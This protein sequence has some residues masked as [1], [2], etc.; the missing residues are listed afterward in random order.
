MNGKMTKE[1]GTKVD[2]RKDKVVVNGKQVTMPDNKGIFW[3]ALNKPKD[4]LSTLDDDKGRTTIRSLIPKASDL[5]LVTV[6]R[7]DRDNTGLLLLTN[8]VG[9]IHPLTH[10]SY[11]ISKRYELV[12]EGFV[13]DAAIKAANEGSVF[14]LTNRQFPRCTLEVL[15]VDKVNRLTLLEF[16]ANDYTSTLIEELIE[17][18]QCKLVSSR[19]TGF[20]PLR[21]KG[22]KKGEWRELSPAE[23]VK[24]KAACKKLPNS[25]IETAKIVGQERAKDRAEKQLQRELQYNPGRI[26]PET[27]RRVYRPG[28]NR[29]FTPVVPGRKISSASNISRDHRDRGSGSGNVDAY[30]N[31]NRPRESPFVSET[32]REAS[33]SKSTDDSNSRTRSPSQLNSQQRSSRVLRVSRRG[34]RDDSEPPVFDERQQGRNDGSRTP[35]KSRHRSPR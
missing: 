7:M 6:G 32:S 16:Q 12:V 4:C 1:L 20:G 28:G 35:S 21:L 5:R 27:G 9:W 33:M 10:P 25:V 26:V 22:L 14:P 31:I 13:S 34:S 2:I 23:I 15:D 17:S 8:E 29:G 11:S 19:R 3:V 30:R 18:M 24:L